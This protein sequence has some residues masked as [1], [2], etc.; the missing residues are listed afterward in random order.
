MSKYCGNCGAELDDSTKVCGKCGTP[1]EGVPTKKPDIKIVDPEKQKKVKRTIKLIAGLIVV[2]VVAIIAV[3][4]I[5]SFTGYNGFL[6]KVMRA[7]EDYDIDTLV[8]LSSDIYYYDTKDFAEYYFEY[9]VGADLD[10]LE[11]NVGHSYKLSYETNEIY[12]LSDR[13]L[14]ELLDNIESMYPDFDLSILSKVVV[15]DVTVTA[16]QGN[17]ST[18]IDVNITMSKEDGVWK[19]LYIE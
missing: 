18:S 16:T 6:R 2:V 1:V 7:Y 5:S 17:Q 3:N 4:I 8:S 10:I 12:T 13:R 14:S 19:L 9:N 15:A 11:G